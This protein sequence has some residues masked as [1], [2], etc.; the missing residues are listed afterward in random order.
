MNNSTPN[1]PIL[2][3]DAVGEIEKRIDSFPLSPLQ[4][5][6]LCATVRALRAENERLKNGITRTL[7]ENLHLADGEIC[8]LIHLKRAIGELK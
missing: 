8:T 6:A 3:D 2:D 1:T 7:S 5:R 4:A